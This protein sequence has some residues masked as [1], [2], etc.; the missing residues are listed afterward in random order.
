VIENIQA[1]NAHMSGWSAAARCHVLTKRRPA[2]IPCH[3]EVYEISQAG[4]AH[5]SGWRA[6]A[7]YHVLTKRCPSH[8]PSH[9]KVFENIQ[10]GNAHMSGWSAAARGDEDGADRVIDDVFLANGFNATTDFPACLLWV[11]PITFTCNRYVK[12]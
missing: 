8:I 9:N 5:M 10:A 1:G 4:N 6:A 7:R 11:V 2:H 3:N 12:C